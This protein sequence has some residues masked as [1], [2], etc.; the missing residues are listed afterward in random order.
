VRITVLDA[1][2][3]PGGGHKV[4]LLGV[5]VSEAGRVDVRGAQV[6]IMARR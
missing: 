3:D 5:M 4:K 6:D 1:T 2:S